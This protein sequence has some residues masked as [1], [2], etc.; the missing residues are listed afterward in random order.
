[1]QSIKT[2]EPDDPADR[3]APA[4]EA[5]PTLTAET[6][7]IRAAEADRGT[8]APAAMPAGRNW[9]HRLLAAIYPP[10]MWMRN[11]L[12]HRLGQQSMGVCAL[13][14]RTAA[15]GAGSEVLL[16]RHSYRPGWFLPGGGLKRGE[17]PLA[18]LARE[19]LEETGLTL[20]A[21]PRL[22]QI[23]RQD[24]FGMVDYPILFVVDGDSGIDGAAQVM[25]RLEIAEID[26]FATDD[27]PQETHV[28]VRLRLA[29]WR[30]EQPV[31]D[32]W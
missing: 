17:A 7:A 14:V 10:A 24:W 21:P 16:V 27:L 5:R 30:G 23:Y 9:R 31:S 19:L 15:A 4:V 25:D 6:G 28:S 18:G 3:A 8:I 1:M 11:C 12:R 32:I 2:S 29:E 13:I 22:Q 20:T 26:W